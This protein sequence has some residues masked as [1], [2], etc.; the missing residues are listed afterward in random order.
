MT[1]DYERQAQE[2]ARE[3]RTEPEAAA[4]EE[5]STAEL[6]A[7]QA[8]DAEAR[9]AAV[10]DAMRRDAAWDAATRSIATR[11]ARVLAAREA[12]VFAARERRDSAMRESAMR[13]EAMREAHSERPPRTAT[14]TPFAFAAPATVPAS[15]PVT[16]LGPVPAAVAV[17]AQA[18]PEHGAV[19]GPERV[20]ATGASAGEA[21]AGPAPAGPVSQ[22]RHGLAEPQEPQEPSVPVG[23]DAAL[24]HALRPSANRMAQD[25]ETFVRLLHAEVER[26]VRGLP[27]GGWRFCERTARTILWLA[28]A[29]QP[30]ERA[31]EALMWLA[32]SN[33]YDGFPQEE[34]VSVGH[35]LVR[36][37]RDMYEANWTSATGSAWVQLYMWMQPHLQAG[38][39]AAAEQVAAE[40]ASAAERQAAAERRAA[41]GRGAAVRETSRLEALLQV[42]RRRRRGTGE[43]NLSTFVSQADGEDEGGNRPDEFMPGLAVRHRF[44][45]QRRHADH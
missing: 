19:R 6:Q 43:M 14:F 31:V 40:R 11:D 18:R 26:Q 10:R 23:L 36:V 37:A 39:A 15:V 28:I 24:L 8:R 25:E 29:E 22:G 27:G 44:P 30:A 7:A 12:A 34:Y 33:C 45:S 35:A 42:P 38:A 16:L 20:A 13:Q 41:R 2:A 17:P 32:E 1:A 5:P 4:P 9:D 21:A 3:V